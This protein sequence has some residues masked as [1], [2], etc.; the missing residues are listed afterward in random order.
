MENQKAKNRMWISLNLVS[1]IFLLLLFYLGKYNQW[2]SVYII[3][4]IAALLVFIVSVYTGFIK[5]NFWKIVHSTSK[6]LDE[7]EVSIVLKAVKYSYS[8]FAILCI[9]LIYVLAFTHFIMVDVV[10]GGGLLYLA[11]IL[12]A[13]VV[14]WN[15][16]IV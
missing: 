6:N 5:T 4:S 15:E 10:L 14:G 12:P 7:R 9:I 2:K 11:H 13:A 8:I 16:K 3:G 1:F